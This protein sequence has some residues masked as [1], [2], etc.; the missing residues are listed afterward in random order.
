MERGDLDGEVEAVTDGPVA[1]GSL[2]RAARERRG[3]TLE[4]CAVSLRARAG[5]IGAMERGDLSGFGG[6][7][8]ARGF[9]RSY[10][11]LVGVDPEEV[12]G[13]HGNDP[14]YVG[15][16]LPQRV[17]LRLR[18][19][20]PGWLL[21]LVGVV[22]VAGIVTAVLGLGGRRAPTAV[23]PVDSALETPAA[24]DV[25]V[26]APTPAPTPT[27]P[28]PVPEGPP[29]DVVMIFERA[30]WLE[31][32]V[33][34]IAVEPGVLVAAGETLRFSGQESV[35]LRLGNAGGVRI[36][37]NGEEL[38]A[39]GGSGEVVRITYGPDGPI[40]SGGTTG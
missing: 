12:L 31:V 30:S 17:P 16:V 15:P 13:L 9:L 14:G 2:L 21:G 36:E 40:E 32:L 19:Q 26:P 38:G 22:V 25:V 33:D 4:E 34:G 20:A 7:I 28:A 27:E 6:D 23:P 35:A 8:Y 39:A 10:A 3:L 18:R 11:R 29:V 5:Q 24:P 1:A 37:L